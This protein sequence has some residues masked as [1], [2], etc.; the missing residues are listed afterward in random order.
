MVDKYGIM[1]DGLNKALSKIEEKDIPVDIVFE[2][3]V[4]VLGLK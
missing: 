2:Q 4:D 1:G 3:G